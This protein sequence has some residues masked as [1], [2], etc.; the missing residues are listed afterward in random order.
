MELEWKRMR[1]QPNSPQSFFVLDRLERRDRAEGEV[2][3]VI[4]L[5]GELQYYMFLRGVQERVGITVNLFACRL[6][7][8]D[9][10]EV[11]HKGQESWQQRSSRKVR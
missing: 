8:S 5:P 4:T 10:K 2:S 3:C 7:D 9:W 11:L 6:M 1:N